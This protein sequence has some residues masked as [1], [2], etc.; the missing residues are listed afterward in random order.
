MRYHREYH[1]KHVCL[2]IL[3]IS[4][5]ALVATMLV[6][7]SKIILED[8]VSYVTNK[9]L[10]MPVSSLQETYIQTPVEVCAKAGAEYLPKNT[11]CFI[12]W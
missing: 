9:G 8:N 12:S 10:Y 4:T 5:I 2:V 6:G 7:P 1:S 3:V 11:Q